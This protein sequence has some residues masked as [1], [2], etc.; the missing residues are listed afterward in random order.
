M[1]GQVDQLP[2]GLP[3]AM[4]RPLQRAALVLQE[5][6][7]DG[8]HVSRHHQLVSAVIHTEDSCN[9]VISNGG[10]QTFHL[11]ASNEI[12][13]QKWVTAL[14]LAKARAVRMMESGE[15]ISRCR[16]TLKDAGSRRD[17]V[18]AIGPA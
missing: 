6:G 18:L 14:E 9:F 11:K 8:A 16:W 5:P 15:Q 10:T 2:E 17:L 12:E 13:R 4:V 7:G 1:A 3:E